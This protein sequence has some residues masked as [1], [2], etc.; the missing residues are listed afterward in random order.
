MRE[1]NCSRWIVQSTVSCQ[2]PPH[3]AHAAG[4]DVDP[5]LHEPLVLQLVA[6]AHQLRP[7]Q[8]RV[9]RQVAVEPDGGM[10]VRVVV[11]E[12][13]IVHHLD[14]GRVAVD[15]EQR[16]QQLAVAQHVH[17]HDEVVGHVAGGD[18]PLLGAE[19][20]AAGRLD[21]RAGDRTRV[22]PGA[23]LGDGV[24]VGALAAQRR[25]QVPLDLLGR[26][27]GQHVVAARH[28]P[29]D[30]IGVAAQLLL[31]QHLLDVVPA[32]PAQLHRVVARVEPA[33]A[34]LVADVAAV[35]LRQ[36]PAGQLR[37]QL[38][39]DQH[40][41]HE[42]GGAGSQ[43]TLPGGQCEV[44][45]KLLQSSPLGRVVRLVVAQRRR[46]Q[47]LLAQH[48]RQPLRRRRLLA[49]RPRP[50]PAAPGSRAGSRTS[51]ACG[52]RGSA[53]R[54]GPPRRRRRPRRGRPAATAPRARS[55]ASGTASGHRHG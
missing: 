38:Q 42:G 35:G 55:R 43:L 37:R 39:R 12:G 8:H 34:G 25:A 50:P 26:P 10:A 46:Q 19:V 40:L 11:G 2:Q 16:R 7:A 47:V 51:P 53:A 32:A 15:Q 44:H 52:R 6:L 27:A 22:R 54:S 49:G 17:H 5:L 3:R 28:V 14:P 45:S 48:R 20:P 31:H 18:E 24:R 30:R 9:R 1:P 4:G 23:A 13:R 21:R 41:V 33:L 36:P 29:P